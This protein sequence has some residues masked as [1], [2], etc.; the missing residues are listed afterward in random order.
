MGRGGVRFKH[1]S[2][3]QKKYL[4]GSSRTSS[5]CSTVRVSIKQ[6]SKLNDTACDM[7][8]HFEIT[9]SRESNT[10]SESITICHVVPNVKLI[11]EDMFNPDISVDILG[12]RKFLI[13]YMLVN[14]RCMNVETGLESF[15]S[16]L[17]SQ[18][19]S[20]GQSWKTLEHRGAVKLHVGDN[21]SQMQQNMQ[22]L[23]RLSL[24]GLRGWHLPKM[25]LPITV[26]SGLKV[27]KA[28]TKFLVGKNNMYTRAQKLDLVAL[29]KKNKQ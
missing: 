20:G 14:A 2:G 10:G 18:S 15:F 22:Q 9:F 19:F 3:I 6:L 21:L 8:T 13:I 24:H 27:P 11:L 17:D 4:W 7:K 12:S 26:H 25:I 28:I 1:I 5:N 16:S 23:S 29:A